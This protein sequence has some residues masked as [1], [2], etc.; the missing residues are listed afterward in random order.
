[1]IRVTLFI[2]FSLILCGKTLADSFPSPTSLGASSPNGDWL[3]RVEP[4]ENWVD[5]SA[6]AY[7]F[8]FDGTSYIQKA[9]FTTANRISPSTVLITDEGTVFAF[10]H[11]DGRGHGDVIYVYKYDGTV[12]KKYS[13]KDLYTEED[14]LRFS[15]T[16]SSIWWRD[17]SSRP[18][19]YERIVCVKDSLGGSFEFDTQT[20][21]FTYTVK[22]GCALTL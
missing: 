8:S 2:I 20:A 18:W 3:L 1:M 5:G 12:V 21:E 7:V 16:V 10:D 13:L 17:Q 6:V 22:D 9:T 14:I 11:W 19:T 4:A 15:R